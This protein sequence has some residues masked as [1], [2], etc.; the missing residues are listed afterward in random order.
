METAWIN[1]YFNRIKFE[2]KSKNDLA[3]LR[4]LQKL[5]L[6]HIPF[7][8]LDIHLH[9]PIIPDVEKFYD[10][11]INRQRGGFC[12]ELNGLFNQLLVAIGFKTNL[13]SARVFNAAGGYGNEFDHLV[14][15]VEL[16]NKKYLTDVGF[17]EFS[18]APLRFETGIH[19][20]D[21]RGIFKIER[22]DE[23][24][25]VAQKKNE[26]D[27]WNNEYLFSEIP[28]S[29]DE[30]T[31][32]CNYHQHSPESHFTQKM[33]CSIAT[34]SGRITLT[35]EALKV[36]NKKG[37]IEKV[38]NSQTE[39]ENNLKKYF[40]INLGFLQMPINYFDSFPGIL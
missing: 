19:Q 30:F 5:H 20:K 33:L 26:E 40:G 7:E 36:T 25:F 12:Y 28:R 37:M 32:M 29:L 27:S 38:I 13:I 18:L 39:F 21:K 1:R 23:N 14:I 10:K 4:I 34:L 6:L 11:I 31:G 9:C 35:R 17:G 3:T 16:R 2:G 8:N 15:L 24:Y 22:F